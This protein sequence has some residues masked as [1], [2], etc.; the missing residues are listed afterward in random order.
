VPLTQVIF[1]WQ[2]EVQAVVQVGTRKLGTWVLGA[3]DN[4]GNVSRLTIR[5]YSLRLLRDCELE[6]RSLIGIAHR[7]RF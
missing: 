1:Q 2:A 7:V 5:G 3:R 6:V 4:A